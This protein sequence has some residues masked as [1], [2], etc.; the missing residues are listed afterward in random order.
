MKA[1]ILVEWKKFWK[2]KVS[3]LLLAMIPVMVFF[4][5]KYIQQ[6]NLNYSPETPQYAVFANFPILGLAEMLMT[7]F[8]LFIIV[9]VGMIVTEEYRTGSL[10]MVLIRSYSFR[11]I[12]LAKFFVLVGLLF[13]YLALYLLVSYCFGYFMFSNPET[14]VQF[15]YYEHF[16]VTEGFIYN[17]KFYCIA[18]FTL[19]AISSVILFI[20]V[21]SPTMT[22]AYGFS[23]GYLLLCFAYPNFIQLFQPILENDTIYKIFFSSIP[24]VQWEGITLLLAETPHYT[25]WILFILLIHIL[26][27]HSL[28]FF[29]TRTKDIFI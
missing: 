1:L 9:I 13:L 18:F 15:Y 5:A 8:N 24:M 19:V 4:S 28:L 29:V 23:V 20:A 2:R 17:L 27:F 26:L 22:S 16:S 25:G 11:K 7:A 3:L 12:I 6:Q 21:I 14:Y 10:R